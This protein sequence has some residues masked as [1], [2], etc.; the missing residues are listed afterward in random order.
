MLLRD[1]T[2]DNTNPSK[3]RKNTHTHYKTLSLSASKAAPTCTVSLANAAVTSASAR[4]P[5]LLS[6]AVDLPDSPP[7]SPSS[8]SLPFP[9]VPVPMPRPVDD[10]GQGILCASVI[11][12]RRRANSLPGKVITT[13]PRKRSRRSASVSSKHVSAPGRDLQL[14][15]LVQRSVAFRISQR[16]SRGTVAFAPSDDDSGM[17]IDIDMQ[18]DSFDAQ[19]RLLVQRITAVLEKERRSQQDA[20]APVSS[21]QLVASLILRH[22]EKSALRARSHVTSPISRPSS[23]LSSGRCTM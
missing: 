16:S 14:M 15:L 13:P 9:C 17:D 12:R 18:C 5:Y 6:T 8:C 11:P 3:R 22:N 20:P 19:D 10:D 23:P 7:V 1:K 2:N 21:P 4:S